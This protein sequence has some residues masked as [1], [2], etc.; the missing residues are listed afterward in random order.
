MSVTLKIEQI[1]KVMKVTVE[2]YETNRYKGNYITRINAIT[3]QLNQLLA[4]FSCRG[5]DIE[6][7]VVK[8]T[9]RNRLRCILKKNTTNSV[10]IYDHPESNSRVTRSHGNYMPI[11]IYTYSLNAFH[12]HYI[13]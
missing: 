8:K 6:Q 10:V 11:V 4:A 9:M 2:N 7:N 13:T 3:R 12:F 5:D 1:A